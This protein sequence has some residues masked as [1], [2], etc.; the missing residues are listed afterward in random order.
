MKARNLLRLP[1][2]MGKVAQLTAPHER[3]V[4]ENIK[5]IQAAGAEAP[6]V[7]AYLKECKK[8]G[9]PQTVSKHLPVGRKKMDA[10]GMEELLHLC[11]NHKLKGSSHRTNIADPNAERVKYAN[12]SG[13]TS[14]YLKK[15]VPSQTLKSG[16]IFDAVKKQ[17]PE[18]TA[19]TY[20]RNCQCFP[21]KD[22]R[23]GGKSLLLFLGTFTGGELVTEHGEKFEERNKW[24][25]P[26]DFRDTLHWNLPILSGTKHSLVAFQSDRIHWASASG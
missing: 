8:L 18:T 25:G 24:M 15:A 14:V 20:N 12:K 7:R 6:T 19:V 2:G 16:P 21:H 11:E 10:G 17:L 26:M 3:L 22:G 4:F 9:L 13:S 5:A 23:N 1:G